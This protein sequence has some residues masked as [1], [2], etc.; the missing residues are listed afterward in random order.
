MNE[1]VHPLSIR[2]LR[3]KAENAGTEMERSSWC[4][5]A[6]EEAEGERE[7]AL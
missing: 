6:E 3:G 2:T 5:A 1:R 7:E 4:G